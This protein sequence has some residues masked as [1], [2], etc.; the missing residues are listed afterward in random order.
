MMIRLLLTA[1]WWTA[2]FE[3]CLQLYRRINRCHVHD[4]A[5]EICM[6]CEQGSF[7]LANEVEREKG[8]EVVLY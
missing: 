1:L 7:C 4:V 2:G 6:R 5:K 8:W 3:R